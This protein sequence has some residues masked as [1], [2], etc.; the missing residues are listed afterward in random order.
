MLNIE[1]DFLYSNLS[2]VHSNIYFITSNTF[3][4]LISHFDIKIKI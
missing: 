4:F 3:H 1:S 2:D